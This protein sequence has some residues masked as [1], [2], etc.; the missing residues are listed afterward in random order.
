MR[1][2]ALICGDNYQLN[3]DD[4]HHYGFWKKT[5]ESMENTQMHWFTWS[6]WHQMPKNFDLYFFLD[7]RHSLWN[8]NKYDYHPRI[9][10]WWDS[11]HTM[12]SIVSQIPLI[13]DKVYLAEFVDTQ[14][15]KMCGMPQVEW[16]PGAF[17]PELYRPLNLEK[18]YDFGFVGQCD[19]TVCRKNMTRKQQ[20]DLLASKYK[21]FVSSNLRGH[22]VNEVYN[23]SKIAIERTIYCNIGTRLFETAGSGAFTLINRHPVFNGLDNIGIDGE[24]FVS[25]DESFDDLMDKM[26][27]YL[28]NDSERNRIATKGQAHFLANHTYKSRLMKIFKDF[29]LDNQYIY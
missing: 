12:F 27:F 17:H 7:Y 10:Y 23:K 29:S 13:F 6:N 26:E 18:E 5:I 22:P 24:H 14:H 15:L 9:L 8:L 25:F 2:I 20:I 16:L 11:F 28:N 1:Q 21:G 3:L 19:D 4:W